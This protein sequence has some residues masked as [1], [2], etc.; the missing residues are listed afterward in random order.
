LLPYTAASHKCDERSLPVADSLQ[1]HA[2]DLATAKAASLREQFPTAHIIGSDQIAELDGHILHKPE[3]EERAI[4]QLGRLAGQTHNLHTAIALHSPDGTVQTAVDVHKMHMRALGSDELRRY[5]QAD[6]PLDC[7][8]SYKIE[9]LGISLF[10][11]IEGDDFTAIT[12]MPMLAL[13][14]QLRSAG[15]SIP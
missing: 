12:G 13:C 7:C 6:Q 2:I 1:Q 15:F 5:V 4:Q 10:E 8:G 3:T 11:R 14:Q 9:S